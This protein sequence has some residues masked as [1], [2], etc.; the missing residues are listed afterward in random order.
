M[1]AKLTLLSGQGNVYGQRAN[2]TTDVT[3]Y[4]VDEASSPIS[5]ADQSGGVGGLTINA[6]DGVNSRMLLGAGL[7]LEDEF[8]GTLRGIV[9]SVNSDF[10]QNLTINATNRMN[11]LVVDRK[12]QPYVGTLGGAFAYYLSL[13][14]IT[15]GYIVDDSI[16]NIPVQLPGWYGKVWDKIKE[17][18][19]AYLVEVAQVSDAIVLRPVRQREAVITRNSSLSWSVSNEQL[20]QSVEV[21]YYNNTY[22]NN[23]LVFPQGGW[24]EGTQTIDNLAAGETREVTIPVNVSIASLKQPYAAVYVDRNYVG[25]DSVYA[26]VGNDNLPI[27]PAQWTAGGGTMS[28]AIGEDSKS[29]VI[30]VTASTLEQYAPYT[31]AVSAGPSDNYSSLRIMGSGIFQDPQTITLHTGLNPDKTQQD[32]GAQIN[33]EFIRTKDQAYKAGT[34]ALAQFTGPGQ[35]ISVGAT[36]INK[37]GQTGI[38]GSPLVSDFNATYAQPMS[39][40]QWNDLWAGTTVEQFND[41]QYSLVEDDFDNQAFG[42]VGGTRVRVEDMYYRIRTAKLGPAG[43]TYEG[44]NDTIVSDFNPDWAGRYVE[45]FNDQWA[46]YTVAEYNTAALRSPGSLGF[47]MTLSDYTGFYE[48]SPEP[49]DADVDLS[50]TSGFMTAIPTGLLSLDADNPGFYEI[51]S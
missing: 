19:P 46:G 26:V 33:N 39:V 17:L 27:T 41:Y 30:T 28:V 14:G 48:L 8:N 29:I 6:T 36:Y 35:K 15:A 1:S 2:A 37:R 16:V 12:A 43:V 18:C 38:V 34:R 9:T 5:P 24:T 45:E 22:N 50:S 47:A 3:Q 49:D 42:N 4:S 21:T 11:I 20:A 13:V 25:P 23:G 7:D 40:D 31:I 51:G 10:T 44:E 32:V